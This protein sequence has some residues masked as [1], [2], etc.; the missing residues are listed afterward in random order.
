MYSPTCISMYVHNDIRLVGNELILPAVSLILNV[1]VY[2]IFLLVCSESWQGE[3][4]ILKDCL[5]VL[6]IH[7][8]ITVT[9]RVFYCT[10][11]V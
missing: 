10:L 1:V 4:I 2:H 6:P 5:Q 8:D 11:Y 7:Y 9:S 3:D